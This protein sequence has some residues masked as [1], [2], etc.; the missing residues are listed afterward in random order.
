VET[1]PID[2]PE[3]EVEGIF[4]APY[5]VSGQPALVLPCA[6]TADGLPIALQLAAAT[7]DDAGLLRAA[8]AVESAL[9]GPRP[10]PAT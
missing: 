3:G 4:T 2:T 9:G 1:P 10:L 5:N 7:G 8:A 6:T